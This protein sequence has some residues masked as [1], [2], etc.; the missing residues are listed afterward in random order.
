VIDQYDGHTGKAVAF[1][2]PPSGLLESATRGGSM[3][4]VFL[5]LRRNCITVVPLLLTPSVDAA[6]GV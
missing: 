6:G 4:P 5:A 1:S 2:S 3:N